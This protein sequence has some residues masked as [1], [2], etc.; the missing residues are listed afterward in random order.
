M[1]IDFVNTNMRHSKTLICRGRFD[2]AFSCTWSKVD[3]NS[4]F[5]CYIVLCWLSISYC[6]P[7]H[8]RAELD[9]CFY[10]ILSW[11]LVSY[12]YLDHCRAELDM[13]YYIVLCWLSVSYC[14][15][16]HCRAEL[17]IFC[18]SVFCW[19]SVSYCYLVVSFKVWRLGF[20]WEINLDFQGLINKLVLIK[21][22]EIYPL[23]DVAVC[24]GL[25]ITHPTLPLSWSFFGLLESEAAGI[26]I[27]N[28]GNSIYP[29]TRRHISDTRTFN[30]T[31]V[32]T[33]QLT[34]ITLPVCHLK[35]RQATLQILKLSICTASW[36]ILRS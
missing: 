34:C 32:I 10:N 14:Y 5:F 6:Y 31:A 19:L 26:T 27:W 7:V 17:D 15:L 23:W 20:F 16:V 33:S 12:G 1:G 36:L 8:C 11:L 30:R 9:M 13:F 29:S 2:S 18:Y 21:I 22:P 35:R 4:T 3:L 25:I 28:V 24:R